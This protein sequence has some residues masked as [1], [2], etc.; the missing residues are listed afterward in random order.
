MTTRTA[1]RFVPPLVLLALCGSCSLFAPKASGLAEVHTIYAEEF[2][3]LIVPAPTG[4]DTVQPAD[5][6]GPG[7]RN[8]P[9]V[10][11]PFERTLAAIARYRAH[12]GENSREAAHLLV[13]KGMVYLQSGRPGLASLLADAIEAAAGDLR[14]GNGHETRDSLFAACFADLTDGWREVWHEF[15]GVEQ[16]FPRRRVLEAA[17]DG[18]AAQLDALPDERLAD[19]MVDSGAT[20]LATSAA[21]F[22]MWAYVVGR[23]TGDTDNGEPPYRADAASHRRAF[24]A[25]GA[26]RI[27]RFLLPEE[28]TFVERGGSLDELA[29]QPNARVRY[30]QWYAALRRIATSA[31]G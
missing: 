30:M 17:A 28:R 24:A 22:W 15:D 16:T 18:I 9:K 25:K 10:D 11:D 20:Y 26:T 3:R 31:D 5:V 4:G 6:Q 23:T 1:T 29:A 27:A 2:A 12:Y 7:A 19:P 21:V 8:T 13:L 14:S